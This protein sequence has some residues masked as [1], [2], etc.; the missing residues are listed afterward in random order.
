[1]YLLAHS[2]SMSSNLNHFFGSRVSS[3]A[4]IFV[5]V[6]KLFIT[7]NV[8]FTSDVDA[9]SRISSLNEFYRINLNDVRRAGAH[10]DGVFNE[11]KIS[12]QESDDDIASINSKDNDDDADDD[13]D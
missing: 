7:S 11:C 8:Y 3:N 10:D 13:D 6:M 1:M 2:S 4:S 5:W 9:K 12:D